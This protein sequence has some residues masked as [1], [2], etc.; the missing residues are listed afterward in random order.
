MSFSDFLPFFFVALK[1][2]LFAF[3]AGFGRAFQEDERQTELVGY[4]FLFPFL[5]IIFIFND[6]GNY[7]FLYL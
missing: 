6:I 5:I 1:G 7:P 3:Y 4:G 2:Y